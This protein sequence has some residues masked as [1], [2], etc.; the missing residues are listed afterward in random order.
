MLKH[1]HTHVRIH[2]HLQFVL[3]DWQCR[4]DLQF[5]DLSYYKQHNGRKDGFPYNK[6]KT[7]AQICRDYNILSGT[8]YTFL[9]DK[10]AIKHNPKG[11]VHFTDKQG[12]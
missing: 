9:Q 10:E 2:F 4:Y 7:K 8:L 11:L 12:E 6:R 5:V 1:S 3:P